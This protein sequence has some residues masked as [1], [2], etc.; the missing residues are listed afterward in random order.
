MLGLHGIGVVI[1][2]KLRLFY[3]L[4][5]QRKRFYNLGSSNYGKIGVFQN[6]HVYYL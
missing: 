4:H 6:K 1:V 3:F 5:R 2:F